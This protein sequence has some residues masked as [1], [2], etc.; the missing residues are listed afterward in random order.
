MAVN[1]RIGNGVP[2]AKAFAEV[3]VHLPCGRQRD[4]IKSLPVTETKK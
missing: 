4:D 2:V 3:G 1:E